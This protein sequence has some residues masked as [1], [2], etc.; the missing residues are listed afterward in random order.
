MA[1][2]SNELVGTSP[3]IE[4]LRKLVDK[5]G[6]SPTRTVLIYGETGTGKGLV[7]RMIHQVS[8]RAARDFV[9]INCAAL[10][11]SLLESELFGHEKGAFTGAVDRK[12]GLVE[13]A[14]QGT[15][16][17]D[18]IREMDLTLQAKLLTLL[19]TQQFRRVGAVKPV[20]VDVRFIAATNKVLLSEVTSGRFREDLYYRLQVVAVNLPALRNRGDDVLTLARHFIARFNRSYGRAVRG[21]APETEDILQRYAWP[22]NVRELENLLERIFILEDENEILPRHL[23]DR[24]LRSV[25]GTKDQ[26]AQP[27]ATDPTDYH[28][29]TEAFQRGLIGQAMSTAGG[30]PQEAARLLGLSRHALRHQMIKLGLLKA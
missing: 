22:G 2:Y 4:S 21:L 28:A 23:P 18:E 17:L 1:D 27:V 13:A 9:D 19:D 15:V 10:P 16:F 11:A 25:A 26:P 12:L 8:S 3:A 6:R 7:A 5:I 20:K 29:A 24:I 14:N 30:N